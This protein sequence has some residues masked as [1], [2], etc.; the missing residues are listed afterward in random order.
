MNVNRASEGLDEIFLDFGSA[1]DSQAE[2]PGLLAPDS[3]RVHFASEGGNVLNGMVAGASLDQLNP[4]CLTNPACESFSMFST[5]VS[6]YVTPVPFYPAVPKAVAPKKAVKKLKSALKQS[7]G[8]D[9]DGTAI[10][11]SAGSPDPIIGSPVTQGS[12][13]HFPDNPSQVSVSASSSS[14]S[15]SS[16]G[17]PRSVSLSSSNVSSSVGPSASTA[18][19]NDDKWLEIINRQNSLMES[20][21]KIFESTVQ[22]QAAQAF[23]VSQAAQA[24]CASSVLSSETA[25]KSKPMPAIAKDLRNSMNIGTGDSAPSKCTVSFLLMQIRGQFFFI[26]E[27]K[28]KNTFSCGSR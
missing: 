18:S 17:V 25:F 22:Q 19:S 14:S 7:S 3:R 2:A 27:K 13:L 24:A 16:S 4:F 11:S 10:S 21:A 20:M 28:R 12:V 1:P 6:N 23:T 26:F 15:S 8:G 5:P 9:R